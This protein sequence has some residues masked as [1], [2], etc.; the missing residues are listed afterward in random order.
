MRQIR[1]CARRWY[2]LLGAL[3]AVLLVGAF[4]FPYIVK[5]VI[6]AHSEEWINRRVRIGSIVL[7]PFTGVYAVNRFTCYEPGSDTVFVSFAKMGVKA[8]LV[9]GWRNGRWRFKDAE[10]REPFARIEQRGS[11]FN[12]SDLLEMGDDAPPEEPDTEG[13]DVAFT[14]TGL[15]LTGGRVQYTGDALAAP[16]RISELEAHCTSITSGQAV[17]DFLVG[18]TLDE[19]GRL[20]G[21]FTIDTEHGRYAVDAKLK[22]FA[23]GQLRPYAQEFM[24]CGT[25]EGNLDLGL[26]VADSYVDTTGLAMSASMMLGAMKLADPSGDELL[27]IG[28]L[29]A[30]LDTLVAAEQRLEVGAVALEGAEASFAL[31]NDGSDNWTR[32]LKLPADSSGA[33]DASVVSESNLFLMLADYIRY[34]GREFVAS[35]YSARSIR[36]AD[37]AVRFADYTPRIPFRYDVEGISLEADRITTDQDTGR[38]TI[39]ARLGGSG[40]VKGRAAF[41]PKDPRNLLLALSV[42]ELQ[43]APLD[44][45]T[46][47]YAAHPMEDGVLSYTSAT[48]LQGG[49]IDSRNALRVERLRFGKRVA[50]HDTGIIVLPL[51]LAAG[52]LKDARGDVSLEL[53]VTGDLNDPQFRAWPIVWKVLKNLV[54]KA[55]S[56]PGK[57]LARAFSGADEADAEG[58]RFEFA[59]GELRKPQRKALDLL[60]KV[61]LARPEMSV[62]LVPLADERAER[63]ELAVFEA[64]RL[65]LFGAEAALS[66]ADSARIAQLP[67]TD[68]L[69]ARFVAQ[70][71][72]GMD[73]KPFQE[74]CVEAAGA[75]HVASLLEQVEYARRE[76]SMQYMLAQGLPPGRAAYRAAAPEEVRGML[77]RPGYRFIYEVPD[78]P[79]P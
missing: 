65:H 34:L 14:V 21:G 51:R 63:D 64:K 54:V 38:V 39:A 62:A 10:L 8:D 68:S 12:F 60:V 2:L 37:C 18:L 32:L 75:T 11:R 48:S 9:A 46:R 30:D 31:L 27:R 15:A 70:R 59:Q 44:P 24:E 5:R 57:A 52:L 40:A 66:G 72:P 16:L 23:L 22:D 79:A 13:A 19:G 7:N 56:A 47:W 74:R 6:E 71:A 28:R 26:R 67:L 1:W 49:M 78:E 42:A 36:L 41:D 17:M 58:V 43:L 3:L 25:L 50:E 53:P 69:F 33:V 73:G 45:Y 55:V 35:A 61:L 4:L 76:G 20:D 77:G 29:A